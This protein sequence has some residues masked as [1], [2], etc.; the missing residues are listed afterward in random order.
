MFL[1]ANGRWNDLKNNSFEKDMSLV[2]IKIKMT[3]LV[4]QSYR[5]IYWVV[6]LAFI[7]SKK[8]EIHSQFETKCS[9]HCRMKEK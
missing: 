4:I 2:L 9:N 1:L 7:S 5:F 8:E 6:I 3:F